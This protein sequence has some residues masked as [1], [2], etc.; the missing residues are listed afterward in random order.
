[1]DKE[2]GHKWKT[3]PTFND[4]ANPKCLD[5]LDLGIVNPFFLCGDWVWLVFQLPTLR[6][7]SP[8]HVYDL[9]F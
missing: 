2:I 1:M 3:T 4:H 6:K 5:M 8:S 7:N 9:K